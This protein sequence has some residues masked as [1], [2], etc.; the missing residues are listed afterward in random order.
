M[1]TGSQSNRLLTCKYNDHENIINALPGS[2]DN[3]VFW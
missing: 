3:R 1:F 2:F